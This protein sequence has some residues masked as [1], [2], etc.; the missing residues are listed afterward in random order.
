MES[1]IDELL[2]AVAIERADIVELKLL[3]EQLVAHFEPVEAE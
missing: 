2:V 1:K 3:V